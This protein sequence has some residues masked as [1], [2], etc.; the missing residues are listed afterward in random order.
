MKP[1][2]LGLESIKVTSRRQAK[3]PPVFSKKTDGPLMEAQMGVTHRPLLPTA[4]AMTQKDQWLS[5]A[6][7]KCSMPQH[8]G[9]FIF[10]CNSEARVTDGC[11]S[12]HL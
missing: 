12:A 3:M 8:P 1:A 9:W 10:A 7:Q 4:W 2:R 5:G 6:P 11:C